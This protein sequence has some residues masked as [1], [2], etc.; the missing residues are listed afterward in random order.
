M[1]KT[2]WQ[3]LFATVLALI[4]IPSIATNGGLDDTVQILLTRVSES[5]YVFIRNGKEHNAR[6]A[7]KHMRRKYE[8][9]E[10]EIET[11]EQFIEFAATKSMMTGRRYR[12]R[13]ADG[14]EMD[15]SDWLLDELAALRRDESTSL[16]AGNTP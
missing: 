15:T 2:G 16:A 4:A 12:I 5:G 6:D 7:A 8:H 3:I 10:D 11:P 9:F 14:T 13:L 1:L